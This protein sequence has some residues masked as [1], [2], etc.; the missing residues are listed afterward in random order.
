[1]RTRFGVA[2]GNDEI[3]SAT[4]SLSGG[5]VDPQADV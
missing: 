4:T 3:T 2:A 5:V 1:L